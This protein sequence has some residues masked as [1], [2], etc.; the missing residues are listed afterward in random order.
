MHLYAEPDGAWA[1]LG[2]TGETEDGR[3]NGI[4]DIRRSAVDPDLY[5]I[6]AGFWS[7]EQHGQA[8]QEFEA[9]VNSVTLK[10]G[11]EEVAP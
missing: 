10:V 8:V 1:W 6:V 5:V 9:L 11:G 7:A 3:M 2:Y 4:T